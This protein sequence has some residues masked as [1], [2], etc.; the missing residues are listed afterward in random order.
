MQKMGG[1]AGSVRLISEVNVKIQK[2]SGAVGLVRV[3]LNKEL[4]FL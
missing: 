3:D 1:E 2:K 4:K